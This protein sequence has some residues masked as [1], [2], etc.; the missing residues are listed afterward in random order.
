M[1][2]YMN[3]NRKCDV[4]SFQGN[5]TEDVDHLLVV[6]DSSKGDT[7]GE[8]EHQTMG[9]RDASMKGEERREREDK[10]ARIRTLFGSAG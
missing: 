1:K 6:D 10:A 7:V 4:P 8:M 9:V 5:V 2:S 3:G